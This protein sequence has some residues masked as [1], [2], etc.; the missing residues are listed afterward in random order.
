MAWSRLED[1]LDKKQI[2]LVLAGPILRQVTENTVTIWV[3][4]KQQAAAVT[5]NVYDLDR[6]PGHAILMTGCATTPVGKNLHIVAIRARKDNAPLEGHV[7]FYDL[8]FKS[9][10]PSTHW[11][12]SQVVTKKISLPVC[13]SSRPDLTLCGL[14]RCPRAT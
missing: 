5:L 1:R 9:M 7:Y 8:D 11:N 4:L 14:L 13:I 6:E 10:S 2:S 12:F 3:P